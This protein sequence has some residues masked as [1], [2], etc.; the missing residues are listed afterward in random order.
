MM[1]KLS[2]C[3]LTF[4]LIVS[5]LA[6]EKSLPA[7]LPRA[8]VIPFIDGKPDWSKLASLPGDFSVNRSPQPTLPSQLTEIRMAWDQ[9]SLWV[10]F[11]CHEK[12]MHSLIRYHSGEAIWQNDCV[13][14]FIDV[15]L[16]RRNWV[17]FICSVDGQMQVLPRGMKLGSGEPQLKVNCHEKQWEA[18]I[19][20]PWSIFGSQ[21]EIFRAAL[22]RERRAG[23]TEYTTWNWPSGFNSPA[24]HGYFFVGDQKT[25]LSKLLHHWQED[26]E[27]LA[28]LASNAPVAAHSWQ[29]WLQSGQKLLSAPML[30]HSPQVVQWLDDFYHLQQ[31]NRRDDTIY[32][33]KIIELLQ[34]P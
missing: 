4:S 11:F 28:T 13:E 2:G 30:P 9:E 15:K 22:S 6:A 1:K 21:P 8:V 7:P 12:N 20:I 24:C 31:S 32:H 16:E 14:F 26:R 5:A 25:I 29:T 33:G 10:H 17:Q 27:F 3:L 18:Q 23:E 34:R 19:Q